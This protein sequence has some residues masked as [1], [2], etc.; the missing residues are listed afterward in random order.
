MNQS[1]NHYP[2]YLSSRLEYS[3]TKYIAI[4]V[5]LGVIAALSFAINFFNKPSSQIVTGDADYRVNA[6]QLF[7]EFT[8]DEK[9]AN[10]KYL[11]KIISVS[12]E[13]ASIEGIDS[14]N[15]SIT[16]K[17]NQHFGVRC[18]LR[19]YNDNKNLN[20]G[21]NVIIKGLCTGKLMDVV[22]VKSTIEN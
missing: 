7:A 1:Y 10:K 6:Y 15:Y 16:L 9:A 11:N 18:Q 5:I 4:S 14:L 20:V 12:G 17:V 22:L 8:E 21:D 3:V 19:Q 13:I 2:I